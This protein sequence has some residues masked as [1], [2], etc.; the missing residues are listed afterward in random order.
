MALKSPLAMVSSDGEG[1]EDRKGHPRSVGTFAR[2]LGRYVREKKVLPLMEGLRRIT[3]LPAQRLQD[4]VAEMKNKGR[5]QEGSDAD[6]T[7]FDPETIRER[8]TYEEPHLRSDGVSYVTVNGTL[9]ID[10]GKVVEGVAPG[11]WLKHHCPDGH[12]PGPA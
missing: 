5:L 3:L 12:E 7:V 8:A 1:L 10:G 6:I 4:S 9:V 2:F 11:R